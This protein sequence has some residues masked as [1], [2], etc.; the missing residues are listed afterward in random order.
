MNTIKHVEI[1]WQGVTDVMAKAN[2]RKTAKKKAQRRK[3][4][5]RMRI[6]LAAEIILILCLVIIGAV[7]FL[8]QTVP[9]S[10]QTDVL[11]DPDT[12]IFVGDIEITG[13]DRKE[14][15]ML[16][17][18][19]YTWNLVI[20]QEDNSY[21]VEDYLKTEIERILDDVYSGDPQEYYELQVQNIDMIASSTADQVHD[22]W[23]KAADDSRIVSYD[24]ETGNFVIS[25]SGTGYEI[26]TQKLEEE[27][28]NALEK[29]QYDLTINAV[30]I[31]G[32]PNITK[33]DIGLLGT[34]TT[35]TTKNAARN[36]NIQLACDAVNGTII[37]PGEQFGYN[38]VVGE[39]TE[40]KGYQFAAAYSN[41]EHVMEIGGGVCQL[42]STIYNAAIAG[43]LQIDERTAHTFEPTYVTPGDDAAVSWGHPDFK[44]TNNS[45]SAIG[46]KAIFENNTVTVEIYGVP[47][48]QAGTTRYL[49]SEKVGVVEAPET[50]YVIDETLQLG[51]E[52]IDKEAVPG[53]K[54][55]TY[56]VE[57]T[58]G[59]VTDRTY[60]HTSRYKGSAA[61]VRHNPIVPD[62][63]ENVPDESGNVPD[64]QEW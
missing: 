36:T 53:N 15:E 9:T 20:Q 24:S 30:T 58:D 50:I 21:Q 27:L 64:A 6:T 62:E 46:I 57:E 35:T 54:W 39:R 43:A 17:E 11:P 22:A 28:R 18:R 52:V 1:K 40:G 26:D 41:G 10:Q 38:E 56:I 60:L 16:L 13:M 47:I 23:S 42:S 61:V 33:D 49:Q 3:R 5:K 14:A 48:L 32:T 34:Y 55:E 12:K 44:F 31:D 25:E 37:E 51:E 59:I 45:E 29:K 4:I 7:L 19:S 8:H 2:R 63:P